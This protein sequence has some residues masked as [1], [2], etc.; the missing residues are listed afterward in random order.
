MSAR[1]KYL[2]TQKQIKSTYPTTAS[3]HERIKDIEPE[4]YDSIISGLK[5]NVNCI[6][7]IHKHI[8]NLSVADT[9]PVI[10]EPTENQDKP[11]ENQD[12]PTENTDQPIENKAKKVISFIQRLSQPSR[13]IPEIFAD[14]SEHY[15]HMFDEQQVKDIAGSYD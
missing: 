6:Q 7:F 4:A 3:L 13:P 5:R 10:D 11:T 14:F 2:L 1:N 15:G 9:A 12:K 8:T